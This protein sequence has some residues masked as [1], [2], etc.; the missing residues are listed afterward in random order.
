MKSQARPSPLKNYATAAGRLPS[1]TFSAAYH[2]LIP[3]GIRYAANV[4]RNGLASAHWKAIGEGLTRF[5]QESGPVLT[6][7]GQ[8]LATRTDLI[9]EEVSRK[10]EALYNRQPAMPRRDL[11]RILKSAFGPRLPFARFQETPIAVGSVGQV[12]RAVLTDGTRVIVKIA[13]PGMANLIRRDMRTLMALVDLAALWTGRGRE[14]TLHMARRIL[15]DL[16]TGFRAEL[17]L[18][19]EAREIEHFRKR[20]RRNAKVYIPVLY[21]N[22]SSRQILVVEELEGESLA[23]YRGR[24]KGDAKAARELAEAV[25]REILT[26]IFDDG[27][28]HADPHAGNFIVMADGRLGLIDFGLTGEFSR[29]DRKR[30]GRAVKAILARDADKVIGALLEFGT[31]PKDFRIEGFKKDILTAVGRRSLDGANFES[32]VN[33]LFA[34]AYKHR[35]YIPNA[36]TLLIKTLVT[37]E[38]VARTLDPDIRVVSI[39]VP[40]ILRSLTPKWLR[41][42]ST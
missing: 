7:I 2:V 14:G 29:H 9:P 15:D 18:K 30:I 1:L 24:K 42:L 37:V 3:F 16:E 21:K 35:V 41:F 13:K 12:H 26:Q 28:F 8:V 10:L 5:F 40:V 32:L 20:M 6:K 34:V 27:R 38:G 39:A 19:A 36:A 33:D 17:D 23:T 22:L 25:L 11:D 31:V 4:R